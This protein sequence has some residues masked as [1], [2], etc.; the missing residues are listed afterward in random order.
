MWGTRGLLFFILGVLLPSQIHCESEMLTIANQRDP[1]L[2][3][4]LVERSEYVDHVFD[5]LLFAHLSA[6]GGNHVPIPEPV[7]FNNL[8]YS[9]KWGVIDG[10]SHVLYVHPLLKIMLPFG[11]GNSG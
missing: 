2:V 1:D 8:T 10:V 5:Q 11:L 3:K 6:K 4:L 7:A 9:H